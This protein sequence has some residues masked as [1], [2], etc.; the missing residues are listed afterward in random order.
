MV[1][2]HY[3]ILVG[4]GLWGSLRSNN[5]QMLRATALGGIGTAVLP[6]WANTIYAVYPT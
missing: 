1:D 3:A 5:A 4:G 6:T 2:L